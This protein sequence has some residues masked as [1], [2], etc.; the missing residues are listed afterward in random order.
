MLKMREVEAPEGIDLAVE[1][2]VRIGDAWLRP[3][4]R[5]LEF[6]G[7]RHL[8]EPRVVQ[9]LAALARQTGSVVGREQ[10]IDLCW[11]GRIVGDDAINRCVAK[12]RKASAS[13]GFTIET[14]PK[15]GYKLLLGG[16]PPTSWAMHPG[17]RLAAF[18]LLVVAGVVAVLIWR[19]RQDVEPPGYPPVAIG[20]FTA[21]DGDPV[22]KAETAEV[23]AQV[24]DALTR[25]GVP[26]Q[27]AQAPSVIPKYLITGQSETRGG[28]VHV[29]VQIKETP[30]G[31][32]ILS[33]ELELDRDETPLLAD[34][35]AA[36]VGNAITRTGVYH[37]LTAKSGDPQ[38][39]AAFLVVG[40]HLA[41]GN[42]LEADLHARRL[43]ERYPD[44]R[45]APF[46]AAFATIH[47]YSA[48]PIE[49]RKAAIMRGR[50]AA[51]LAQS[52]LPEFGDVYISDCWL[53]PVDFAACERIYRRALEIDPAPPVLRSYLAWQLMHAGRL[54]EAAPLAARSSADNPFNPT[55]VH[56][57]LYLAEFLGLESEEQAVWA[58]AQR[59]WPKLRFAR[60]RFYGLMASGRW[61]EA[62]AMLPLVLRLQPDSREVLQALFA[63]LN[64]PGAETTRAAIEHCRGAQA[65]RTGA[66]CF[67]GLSMLDRPEAALEVAMKVFPMR[68]G[69]SQAE[70]EAL[71]IRHGRDGGGLFLLWGEGAKQMR[72]EP[73]FAALAQR[74]GLL[75]YWK[76]SGPPDFC[77]N[78]RAPVCKLI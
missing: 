28:A 8:I 76:S 27:T 77:Q 36:A 10:L 29:L 7:R 33:Q 54:K 9:L 19:D 15:V 52:R 53:Y 59:Y 78:E 48:L 69:A 55:M 25:L 20:A 14:V 70:N 68:Q 11:G 47:A 2:D 61:R 26:A 72:Q 22:L 6:E 73:G 34:K 12:A 38:E 58:Y 45:V 66:A 24:A 31:T 3:A 74:T 13:A 1:P 71:F 23:A 51:K 64:R 42:A 35:V 62:E 57:R 30:T 32:T 5:V 37:A 4:S 67:T 65:T 43:F 39:T 18:A 46:A 49:E 56:H 40:M 17:F 21:R 50:K 41:A 44:S 60:Q 75:A 16:S 63:A